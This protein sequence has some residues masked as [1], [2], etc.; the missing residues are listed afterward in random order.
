MRKREG[1]REQ[2]MEGGREGGREGCGWIIGRVV[3]T[4][5]RKGKVIE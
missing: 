5:T 1:G 3:E 4:G 2:G